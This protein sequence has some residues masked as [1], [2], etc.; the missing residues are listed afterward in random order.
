MR[1][2]P[3]QIAQL[4]QHALELRSKAEQM[5]AKMPPIW[6]EAGM[7]PRPSRYGMR[8]ANRV[9]GSYW[10]AWDRAA[11]LDHAADRL[12]RRLDRLREVVK[13]E[14]GTTPVDDEALDQGA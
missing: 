6:L 14:L 13:Q 1:E 4:R 8:A 5:R 2:W 7:V 9:F 10:I 3:S 12:Q 11:R